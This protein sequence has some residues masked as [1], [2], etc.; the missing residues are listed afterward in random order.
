MSDLV[1]APKALEAQGPISAKIL[2]VAVALSEMISTCE[3]DD[4]AYKRLIRARHE[5]ADAAAQAANLERVA[6]IDLEEAA[7]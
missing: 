1:Y 5:L 2:S 3:M 4:E 7:A 6:I